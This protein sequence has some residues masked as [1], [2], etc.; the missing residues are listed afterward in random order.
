MWRCLWTHYELTARIVCVH[1]Q[2]EIYVVCRTHS[3]QIRWHPFSA[4]CERALT[5]IYTV[6]SDCMRA[7]V[8]MYWYARLYCVATNVCECAYS[9]C[10]CLFSCMYR[11][12][13]IQLQVLSVLNVE[14]NSYWNSNIVLPKSNLFKQYSMETYVCLL[15]MCASCFFVYRL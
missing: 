15:S 9:I 14:V 12:S 8:C 4:D 13:V 10:V 7:C 5:P 6:F 1:G 11:Y 3:N 2:S